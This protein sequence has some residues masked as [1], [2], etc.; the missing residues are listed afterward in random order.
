MRRL[1][2]ATA[3]LTTLGTGV[4]QAQ[5]VDARHAYQQ[6]RVAQGVRSGAL[7]PGETR[8]IERQQGSIDREESRMRDHH[9]GHLTFAD[10]RALQYRE[11]RASRHIYYAKHN[12]R[13]Y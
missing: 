7:T 3:L 8:R 4:A 2:I 9:G 1:L 12:G 5:T 10:R 6:D 13:A 11:N